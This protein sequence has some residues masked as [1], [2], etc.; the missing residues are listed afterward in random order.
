VS[1]YGHASVTGAATAPH[2]SDSTQPSD[3]FQWHDVGTDLSTTL[4]GTWVMLPASIARLEVS[5]T[6]VL[7]DRSSSSRARGT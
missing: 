1:C 3:D 6:Y 2:S 4:S 5:E 7:Y